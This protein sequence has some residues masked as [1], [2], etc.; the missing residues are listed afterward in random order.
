MKK[1]LIKTTEDAIFPTLWEM[2]ESSFPLCERRALEDQVQI[3]LNDDYTLEAWIDDNNNLIGFISWWDCNDW[4]YVEHYAIHPTCRSGGYGSALLREWINENPTPV[5]LEIE[6]VIDE[7][8]Q[9][10]KNFY[11]RLGFKENQIKHFQLPYH[12]DEGCLE[13]QLLSYPDLIP[14][15]DYQRFHKKKCKEIMPQF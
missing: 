14:E 10:R 13:M 3:F 9:R 12:K 6:L 1:I 11:F 5:V 7:I 15:D 4:R 8:T 2:Y